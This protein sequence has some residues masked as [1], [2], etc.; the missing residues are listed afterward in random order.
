MAVKKEISKLAID[1]L[2]VKIGEAKVQFDEAKVKTSEIKE[3]IVSAGYTV[4]E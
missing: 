4:K 2:D 3:A 1:D